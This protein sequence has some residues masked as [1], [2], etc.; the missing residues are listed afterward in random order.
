MKLSKALSRGTLCALALV[1]VTCHQAILTAPPD[2]ILRLVVNPSFISANGGVAVVTAV[3]TEGIGT[4]V[5]DG[6]VVQ[7][8]TSLGRI[9]EQG[10]TN[11]GV[12]RVNLI[13]DSRSG[14]ANI[15]A[16]SGLAFATDIVKVGSVLPELVF[17]TADP[18]FIPSNS[19]TTHIIATVLDERGN[20]V[21]NVP[22]IFR[23]T[24]PT[25]GTE[26]MESGSNPIFTDNSGRAEDILR[27]RRPFGTVGPPATVSVF[28]LAPGMPD[29]PA[30][31][32]TVPIQ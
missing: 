15:T 16:I 29:N 24:A 27:T 9:D 19:R 8:F 30:P 13:S 18:P 5:P 32:V 23:V 1:H 6:T 14:D 28:V 31:S 22:V 3:V 2:S 12:A 20:P 21:P 10:K 11:D 26:F 7:F 17:V 25:T 4:P